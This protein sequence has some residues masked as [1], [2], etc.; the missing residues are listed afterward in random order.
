MTT[1]FGCRTAGR[2]AL[3]GVFS[4]PASI[5]RHFETVKLFCRVCGWPSVSETA[6][7]CPIN[8]A[9]PCKS[10]IAPTC[11]IGKN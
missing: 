2:I 4:A 9:L 3:N 5:L 6:G 10:N 7:Y 1:V 8:S 11:L